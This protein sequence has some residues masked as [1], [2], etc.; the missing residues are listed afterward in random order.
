[1]NNNC[2]WVFAHRLLFCSEPGKDKEIRKKLA[3][4]KYWYYLCITR[5]RQASQRCSNV[6]VVF[7]IP[8]YNYL[9]YE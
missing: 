6:R 9:Y 5:T 3:G 4:I 2:R 1:M 8:I 7:L